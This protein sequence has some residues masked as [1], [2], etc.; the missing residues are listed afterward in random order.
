MKKYHIKNLDCANCTTNIEEIKRVEP[1]VSISEMTNEGKG[2]DDG[3]EDFDVKKELFVIGVSVVLFFTG[4]VFEE[5]LHNTSFSI[6]E[7]AVLLSAY[8]L[9]GW[10]VLLRAGRNIIHGKVFDENFLMT[11]ATLGAIVI[12]QIPE[13]VGVMIFFKVGEFFQDLSVNR[14]RKSIK[15]LLE[16]RPDHANLKVD[17]TVKKVSPDDVKVE[18]IVIVKPGEKVP[19]DGVILEGSSQVDTSALTGESV[20]RRAML[21]DTVLAGMINKT[22][23]LTVQVTRAFNESSVSQILDLVQHSITKKAKTE[24]FISRFA[25]Y[26]TPAVVGLAA[27]VAVLPPLILPDASF[28][29]W[30]YR[31]LVLL[32]ISCPC[33]LVVSIPLGYFG[34]IGGASRQGILIKGSNYLDVLN[35]VKTVVFDK[36]GTLTKG[37]FKVIEIIPKNGFSKEQ[38]LKLAA[39]AES[40]SNHPI[41]QSIMDAY[42]ENN[43]PEFDEYVELAGFGIK[44]QVNGKTL[45]AGNDRLLHSEKVGHEYEVCNVEGTVVHVV[46][47]RVYAGYLIIGDEIKEDA[48]EAISSLRALGV[49]HIKL[50]TGDSKD[51]AEAVHRKLSLDS[52]QAELLPEEK[53]AAIEQIIKKRAKNERIAFVGDGTNDAPVIAQADVGIAMGE[54]GTDAAIDIADIVLMTDSPQKV[55][56]AIQ[57]ARRT[58]RIVWE[59]IGFAF[60]VKLIFVVLGILGVATMWVAVFADMGV[61]LMAIFN[62]RRILTNK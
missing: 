22:S 53:V 14:S 28:S 24:K 2:H 37:V 18:D 4:I 54:F 59:N 34:G 62:A 43:L 21:G 61:A 39:E 7:Y 1:D 11:I 8:L 45:L 51:V 40:H 15:A 46:A 26:Y 48:K 47:G 23:V 44:A 29:E 13:A 17:G 25:R 12:H 57:V 3:D 5:R 55:A 60:F 16:T 9:C 41:A 30:L 6:A 36:T 38:L 49:Q 50:L 27:A 10:K 32:V 42:G 35:K 20:P 56:Q 52:F 31:A 58:H 19:L 33:A